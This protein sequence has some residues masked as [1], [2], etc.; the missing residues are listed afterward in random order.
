[1][2]FLLS[3]FSLYDAYLPLP[4]PAG[5][6]NKHF[7]VQSKQTPRGLAASGLKTVQFATFSWVF[8]TATTNGLTN[9]SRSRPRT[10]L[11]S[12]TP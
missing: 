8:M 12:I 3:L 5:E 6:A 4:T 7:P 10:R 2:V 1:V 11:R 9:R